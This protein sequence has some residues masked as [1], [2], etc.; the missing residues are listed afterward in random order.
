MPLLLTTLLLTTATEL[1]E[2]ELE[3]ACVD[4]EVVVPPAQAAPEITGISAA[5]APLVP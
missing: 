1:L 5:A 4:E 2:R 3:T